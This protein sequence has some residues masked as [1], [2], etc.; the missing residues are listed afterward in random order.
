M[1][2]APIQNPE[3]IS[4]VLEHLEESPE[5]YGTVTR[6]R[7]MLTVAKEELGN[8]FYFTPSRIAGTFHCECPPLG[9]VASGLLNSGYEVSRSHACPGSLKTS[10][11][12]QQVHDLFRNWIKSHPVRTDKLSP[13]SP[14]QVLLSKEASEDTDFT[15]HP[16]S[17]TA[18]SR[19][20]LVRYQQNPTPFWGPGTK[21]VSGKRKRATEDVEDS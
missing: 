10:A 5:R 19:M 8:P 14:A 13:G 15:K 20:K 9:D 12:R 3:F 21:A 2:S 7:G 6:M 4:K 16:D 18:S 1:W 11:T 17:V